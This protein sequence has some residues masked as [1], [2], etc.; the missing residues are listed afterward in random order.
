VVPAYVLGEVGRGGR[1]VGACTRRPAAASLGTRLAH[2]APTCPLPTCAAQPQPDGSA[3]WRYAVPAD[4]HP[5]AAPPGTGD[6]AL[7]AAAGGPARVVA[8]VGSAHVR[9]MVRR[10]PEA[11]AAAG[12]GREAEAVATLLADAA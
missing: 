11:L 3:L 12:A 1:R 5:R 4:G 7:Q 2:S 9:G 6:G 10:W 8:V